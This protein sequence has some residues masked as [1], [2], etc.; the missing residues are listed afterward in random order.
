MY[1]RF[2]YILVASGQIV[3]LTSPYCT[4][5]F[6]LQVPWHPKSR[7]GKVCL[8]QSVLAPPVSDSNPHYKSEVILRRPKLIIVMTQVASTPPTPQSNGELLGQGGRVQAEFRRVL[9]PGDLQQS[10]DLQQLVIPSNFYLSLIHACRSGLQC[11]NIQYVLPTKWKQH[12]SYVCICNV[13]G[14]PQGLQDTPILF[15]L[16]V[17]QLTHLQEMFNF[18]R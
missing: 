16:N 17:L 1:F 3:F 5:I 10:W 8:G 11:F 15:E 14:Q 6:T 9:H 4:C 2:C 13:S 12:S 7:T 18:L